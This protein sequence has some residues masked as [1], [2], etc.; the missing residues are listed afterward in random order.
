VTVFVRHIVEGGTPKILNF[1]VRQALHV[2]F[3]PRRTKQRNCAELDDSQNLLLRTIDNAPRRI[4][5]K[6]SGG[7]AEVFQQNVY[8]PVDLV[9]FI[10]FASIVSG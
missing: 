3:A 9:V 1:I 4:I 7:N 2:E 5:H 10:Y 8:S 6:F